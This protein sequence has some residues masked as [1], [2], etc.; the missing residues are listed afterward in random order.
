MYLLKEKSEIESVFQ[1]FYTMVLTQF[2][3]KIK[4][5]RSDNG[6]EYLYKI[7]RNFFLEKW[8][9]HQSSC[10]DTPQHNGVAEKKNKHLLEVARA[11][12]F[13]KN[14]PKYLWGEAILTATYLIDRMPS[15]ILNFQTPLNFFKTLN[16][17]SRLTSKI[18]LKVFGC[19]A[20][21]HNHEH[22]RGKLDHRARKCILVGYAPTQKGYKCFDPISRKMFMTMDV[23][24][25]EDKPF[26]FKSSSGGVVHNM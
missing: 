3:E 26:F 13:S 7:L 20:F 17:I 10:K 5:V 21:V 4:I 8:I 15:R 19:I 14:V 2:Q 16:P 11:L 1:N 22:G 9:V 24:F 18:A 23:T 25:F 12:L 6:K